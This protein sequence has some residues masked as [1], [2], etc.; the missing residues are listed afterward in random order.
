MNV[1]RRYGVVGLIVL[2]GAASSHAQTV[3]KKPDLIPMKNML[4]DNL[5]WYTGSDTYLRLTGC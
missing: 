2:L 3:N 4:Y 5:H 1:L